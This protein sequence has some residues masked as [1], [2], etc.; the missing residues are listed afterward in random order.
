MITQ[1]LNDK[2][3]KLPNTLGLVTS[4]LNP[5]HKDLQFS[6]DFGLYN[7]SGFRRRQR[8]GCFSLCVFLWFV[9]LQFIQLPLFVS[10]THNVKMEGVQNLVV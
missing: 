7:C 1:K 5:N 8:R 3:H 6:S 4:C 2:P 10:K 9:H